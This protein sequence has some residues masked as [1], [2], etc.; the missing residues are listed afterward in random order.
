MHWLVS[1]LHVLQEQPTSGIVYCS[2]FNCNADVHG[3]IKQTLQGNGTL[4]ENITYIFGISAKNAIKWAKVF[5]LEQRPFNWNLYIYL[6]IEK[7]AQSWTWRQMQSE[8]S[9]SK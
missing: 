5:F 3:K 2:H 8:A 9:E 6:S 1:S 4:L 7:I